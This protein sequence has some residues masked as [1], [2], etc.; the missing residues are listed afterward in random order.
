MKSDLEDKYTKLQQKYHQCNDAIVI[1]IKKNRFIINYNHKLMESILLL[2]TKSFNQI[3]KKNLQNQVINYNVI[4]DD[5]KDYLAILT[6]SAQNLTKNIDNEIIEGE[7][8]NF[9][10]LNKIINHVKE[11]IK[12]S[13]IPKKRKL[14]R[15]LK[16]QNNLI[17]EILNWLYSIWKPLEVLFNEDIIKK[18]TESLYNQYQL[19]TEMADKI[20]SRRT[21]LNN[22]FLSA[23]SLFLVA[24]GLLVESNLIHWT[25]VVLFLAILFEISWLRLIKYYRELNKAKFEIINKIE[26]KLPTRGYTIEWHIKK[27][28]KKPGK[29]TRI[30]FG[31]MW[32][33][34]TLIVFYTIVLVIVLVW[35]FCNI[36]ALIPSWFLQ[37]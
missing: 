22:F 21:T 4:A 12:K 36:Q 27:T 19:F 17:N 20:S 16:K 37:N 23:N 34:K 3:K 13:R 9:T 6:K 30:S 8:N 25:S 29:H 5:L 15:L 28:Y 32:I 24:I 2:I 11:I 7:I 33:P 18:D 26:E 1:A 35:T 31:E 14:K 10:N